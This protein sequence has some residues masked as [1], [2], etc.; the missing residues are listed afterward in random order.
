MERLY[1]GNKIFYPHEYEKEIGPLKYSGQKQ[2]TLRSPR[3]STFDK[4]MR[5]KNFE[6]VF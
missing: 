5:A 1:Y 4:L 6:E 2:G 3:Y